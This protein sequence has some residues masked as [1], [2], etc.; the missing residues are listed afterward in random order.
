MG[1]EDWELTPKD[2]PKRDPEDS[3]IEDKQD[4]SD[5]DQKGS[6]KDEGGYDGPERRKGQRRKRED[7][8]CGDGTW[9]LR[10]F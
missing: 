3:E 8:R 1:I 10:D 4:D 9:N 5:K 7:R 6:K 2:P